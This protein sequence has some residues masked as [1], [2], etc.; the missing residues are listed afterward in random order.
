MSQNIDILGAG[1]VNTVMSTLQDERGKSQ[2]LLFLGRT[3][4]VP[5]SDGEIMA[6]FLGH[7][8]IADLIADGQ[9][10]A[11]YS[12]GKFSLVGNSVPNLK[13][14]TSLNQEQLNQ[15]N[16]FINGG[17][18]V[19]DDL[20]PMS[21]SRILDNL[22]LGVQQRMEALCVAARIGGFSY[23]RLGIKMQG[24]TFGMPSD[25]NITIATPLT[26]AANA[27]PVSDI[28]LA[29]RLG[30]VK[31]GIVYN[32]ITMTLA[33][34][35]AMIATIEFI[36]KSRQF[37]APN[38]SYLNLNN[39]NTE[40]MK[41][42]A[43]RVLG[44][45]TIELYDARYWGQNSDGSITSAPFLPLNKI[46]L[47]SSQ[48]D[49]NAM[50]FDFANGVVTESLISRFGGSNINGQLPANARGP[51]GYT[52]TEDNPPSVTYWGVGR[53]FPRR[54]LLQASACLTIAPDTGA[55]SISE[56]INFGE[57]AFV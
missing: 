7:I 33:A 22:R 19:Q 6:H 57:I 4:L 31:Y 18:N 43:Q 1:R 46:I 12:A 56:T 42:L 32:R 28:L 23:D 34:F 54:H 52:T 51:V 9:R 17:V 16:A 38:V 30:Q 11:T 27:T 35:G 50:A 49:N 14:G 40:D 2:E 55:G 36:N 39:T 21:E 5:A 24:V 45:P 47:E 3:P 8:L 41:M 26:D 13:I 10:A 53:G 37:L 15:L 48:N 29:K 20:F 44:I 25:L